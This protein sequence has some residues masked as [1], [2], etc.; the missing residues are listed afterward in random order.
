MRAA[1]GLSCFC[2]SLACPALQVRQQEIW[3]T[4]L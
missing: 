4:K 1:V 2:L 3:V